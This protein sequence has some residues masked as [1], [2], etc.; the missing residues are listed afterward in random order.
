MSKFLLNLLLQI[1]KALLNSKI[2]LLHFRSGYPSRP[3]RPSA[4][5]APLAPLLS[6][7]SKPTGRPKPLSPRASLTYLQKYVF[8]L[9][10]RLS[11]AAPT[12]S[13]LA[14][15]WTPL[16]SFF[17]STVPPRPWSEIL[18]AAAPPRRPLRASDA[19]E[20]L[21]LPPSL[22][23]LI[24]LQTELLTRLNGFNHHLPPP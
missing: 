13:P 5:P 21:P 9:I 17:F 3:T 16:V 14:D 11:S 10:S 2:L 20:P 18:R 12:L 19:A 1:S 6:R 7:R 23:P 4:Q 15:A 22:L 24:P 8:F